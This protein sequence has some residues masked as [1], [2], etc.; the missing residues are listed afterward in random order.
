MELCGDFQRSLTIEIS[1]GGGVMQSA[2]DGAPRRTTVL[3]EV[4]PSRRIFC[5][6]LPSSD[7]RA[8]R[9]RIGLAGL[10]SS[11]LPKASQFFKAG[12]DIAHDGTHPF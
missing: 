2:T 12:G 1:Q 10:A 8:S 6:P 4:G 11:P 5:G 7:C 3:F 9:C